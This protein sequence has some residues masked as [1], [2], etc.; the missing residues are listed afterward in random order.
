MVA[1]YFHSIASYILL[2]LK[3]RPEFLKRNP[4]GVDDDGFFY[5][6]AG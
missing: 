4:N 5:K 2:F 3:D 6:N 1:E